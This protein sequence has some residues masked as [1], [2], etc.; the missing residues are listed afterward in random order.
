MAD[1][2]IGYMAGQAQTVNLDLPLPFVNETV[3]IRGIPV[4]MDCWESEQERAYYRDKAERVLGYCRENRIRLSVARADYEDFEPLSWEDV[5][6]PSDAYRGIRYDRDRVM[7]SN[8]S[9][10]PFQIYANAEAKMQRNEKERRLLEW[11]VEKWQRRVQRDDKLL[12]LLRGNTRTIAKLRWF[13]ERRLT[14]EE[15]MYETNL[16]MRTIQRE[17]DRVIETIAL[18]LKRKEYR[19]VQCW[20]M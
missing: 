6:D 2:M 5:F 11:E 16:S 1:T 13:G 7:T 4:R 8:I 20:F 19:S 9:D 18:Y 14:W 12:D 3:L 10:E 15:V 17:R